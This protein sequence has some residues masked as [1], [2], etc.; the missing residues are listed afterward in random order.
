MVEVMFFLLKIFNLVL[1]KQASEYL[2]I[3]D[4]E[5]TVSQPLDEVFGVCNGQKLSEI[6]GL[7]LFNALLKHIPILN[8]LRSCL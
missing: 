5:L 2:S 1:E 4:K 6:D 7:S 3:L 8:Y